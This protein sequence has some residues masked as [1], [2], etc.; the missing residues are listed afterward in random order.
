LL[1]QNIFNIFYMIIS[2]GVQLHFSVYYSQRLNG[3]YTNIDSFL[4][5]NGLSD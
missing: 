1:I 3:I 5:S 4:V 2:K